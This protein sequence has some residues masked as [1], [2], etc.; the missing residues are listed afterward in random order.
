MPYGLLLI[1]VCDAN[2]ACVPTLFEL[3]AQ[4]PG[5]SV[6]ETSC[7]S[8]CELCEGSPYVLLDGDIVTASSV[9]EL[10]MTLR[11]RIHTALQDIG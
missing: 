6:L 1:E 8:Q 11:A 10:L 4:F 9:E 3:E 7:L 5:T 2:P